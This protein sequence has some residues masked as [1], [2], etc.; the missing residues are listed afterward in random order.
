MSTDST[1]IAL[2][3]VRHRDVSVSACSQTG[4]C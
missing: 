3:K 4:L 2:I 1:R